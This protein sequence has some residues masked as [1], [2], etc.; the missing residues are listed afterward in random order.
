MMGLYDRDFVCWTAEMARRL[1]TEG[2]IAEADIE[3]VAEE[4]EDMGK[5]DQREAIS[6][7]AVLVAHLL[8]WKYQPDQRSRSWEATIAT[9]R[10][11][12]DDVLEQSP[13]L[14]RYV[15]ER[16][17]RVY[18]KAA[19]AAGTETGLEFPEVCPFTFEEAIDPDFLP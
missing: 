15:A 14:R 6:R 17:E 5:R 10:L 19:L 3:H 13:S 16:W 7:A 4:I 11:E 8:K 9:Q 18:R 2:H 1:R 12:L